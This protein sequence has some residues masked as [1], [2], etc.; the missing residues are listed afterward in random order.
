MKKYLFLDH[1]YIGSL[2]FKKGDAQTL[3]LETKI[4]N[5]S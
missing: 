5:R 3:D 4:Y 1:I 2:C